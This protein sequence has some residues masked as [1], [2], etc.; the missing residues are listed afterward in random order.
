MHRRVK[1]IGM[2]RRVNGGKVDYVVHEDKPGKE[3]S[4]YNSVYYIISR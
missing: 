4:S 3:L 1:Y 2:H